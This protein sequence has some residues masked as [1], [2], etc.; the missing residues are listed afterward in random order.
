MTESPKQTAARDLRLHAA[1]AELDR[2]L[3]M[4]KQEGKPIGNGKGTVP[5]DRSIWH[6]PFF[7]PRIRRS[8]RGS[9]LYFGYWMTAAGLSNALLLPGRW[10]SR[11]GFG[12]G[13]FGSIGLR[14]LFRSPGSHPRVPA[15]TSTASNE[16]SRFK[17]TLLLGYGIPGDNADL[18]GKAGRA[19][20]GWH[21]LPST[22]AWITSPSPR[23]LR[24][25]SVSQAAFCRFR[26]SGALCGS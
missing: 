22:S 10:P 16:L 25:W 15:N 17:G 2:R 26:I 21:Q 18:D 13:V 8:R 7:L 5:D 12:G 19:G 23:P 24:L 14:C 9:V 1:N 4:G 6:G 3:R 11:A 20:C